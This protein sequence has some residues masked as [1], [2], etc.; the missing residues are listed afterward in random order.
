MLE[1]VPEHAFFSQKSNQ[2]KWVNMVLDVCAKVFGKEY[3]DQV[4]L[5]QIQVE[6]D[7]RVPKKL[8]GIKVGTKNAKKQITKWIEWRERKEREKTPGQLGAEPVLGQ[9]FNDIE[10][11][12][13]DKQSQVKP[14]YKLEI[15]RKDWLTEMF[16]RDLLSKENDQRFEGMGAYAEE[17]TE[18]ATEKAVDQLGIKG[19][20]GGNSPNGQVSGGDQQQQPPPKKKEAPI[21]ELR[22][23]RDMLGMDQDIS[24]SNWEEKVT[25]LF[26]VIDDVN[27]GTFEPG[28]KPTVPDDTTNKAL[29]KRTN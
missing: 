12:P 10:P 19:N 26:K 13:E 1:L 6:K 23:M 27:D 17:D 7:V 8:F 25:S 16:N 21:F 9:V 18:K 5:R 28:G 29:W 14:E 15:T 24:L 2:D 4:S 3:Y 11:L 22:G 20:D